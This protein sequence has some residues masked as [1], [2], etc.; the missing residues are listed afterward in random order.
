MKNAVLISAIFALSLAAVTLVKSQSIDD[1]RREIEKYNEEIQASTELLDRTRQQQRTTQT[2]LDAINSRIRSRQNMLSSLE[3]EAAAIDNDIESKSSLIVSL[4]KEIADLKKEYGE[5]VYAAYKNYKLN[6]FLLFIFAA[7][8]F[9][10]ATQRVEFMRRYNRMREQKAAEISILADSI[11]GEVDALDRRHEELETNKASQAR[12]VESLS[13]DQQQYRSSVNNLQRTASQLDREVKEKQELR[14]KAQKRINEII[15]EQ[16][17]LARS[18]NLSS[19]DEQEIIALSGRF[20]DN[21]GRLPMPV[22]RGVVT[23]RFGRQ[24]TVTGLTINSKGYNISAVGGSDVTAVFDGTVT[25]VFALDAMTKGVTIRH[26]NYISVYSNLETVDVKQGD[27]VSTG[28][29]LGKIFASSNEDDN[30]LSFQIWTT[31]NP[32]VALNPQEWLR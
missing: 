14:D 24:Q 11:S 26:G 12:E 29:R 13:R 22:R 21:K 9:N 16:A 18:G 27:R 10:E 6:N 5:M 25:M 32:P 23:M 28:Q 17:R 2:Q 4:E 8:D 15:E 3:K 20:E 30:Y 19:E 1:L 7:E 31:A